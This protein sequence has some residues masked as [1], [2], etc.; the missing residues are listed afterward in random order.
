MRRLIDL[1]QLWRDAL[2][3]ADAN[4]RDYGVEDPPDFPTHCPFGIDEP[5]GQDFDVREAVERIRGLSG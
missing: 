4:V 5:L 3:L 1:D 2:R